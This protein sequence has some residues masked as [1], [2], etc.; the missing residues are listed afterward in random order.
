MNPLSKMYSR[1]A[2]LS[3]T[4]PQKAPEKQQSFK[5]DPDKSPIR[6]IAGMKAHGTHIDRINVD[7]S[8]YDIPKLEYVYTLETELRSHKERIKKMED[9]IDRLERN[10]NNLG[11][12]VRDTLKNY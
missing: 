10:L 3:N 4:S 12:K 11:A 5:A 7:G 9:K 2:I 6:S 8:V 1:A